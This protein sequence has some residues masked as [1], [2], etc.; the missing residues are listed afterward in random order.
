MGKTLQQL[1]AENRRLINEAKSR[2]ELV[3]IGEERAKLAEQ[4]KRLLKQL[5]ASPTGNQIR[6]SLGATGRGFFKVGKSVGK[7][8][9]RYGRFLNK[10]EQ[11]NQRRVQ[12]V[13]RKAKRIKKV[14]K[15][16]SRKTLK[17]R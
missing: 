16:K 17:R 3:K 7:G 13:K 12:K 1:Q 8:L 14:S 15:T 11:E 2:T 10:L 9:M 5:R 4:N 6:K